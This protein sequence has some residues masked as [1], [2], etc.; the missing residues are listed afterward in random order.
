MCRAPL[1]PGSEVK[2]PALVRLPGQK[3]LES[4][5]S[6]GVCYFKFGNFA[7]DLRQLPAIGIGGAQVGDALARLQAD[8]GVVG[9]RERHAVIAPGPF[10][11]VAAVVHQVDPDARLAVEV[12]TAEQL[13]AKIVELQ[14]KLKALEAK[15]LDS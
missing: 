3:L 4:S 13:E 8:G 11:E 10:V 15:K 2:S 9:I 6:A 1:Q 7:A 12:E 5:A 14:T